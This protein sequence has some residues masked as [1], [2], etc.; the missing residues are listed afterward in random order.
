MPPRPPQV[1]VDVGRA[2]VAVDE[3]RAQ[4]EDE[5]VGEEEEEVRL[6]ETQIRCERRSR[7]LA[8]MRTLARVPI[9]QDFLVRRQAS[10]TKATGGVTA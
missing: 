7:R 6:Q 5:E 3:G 9:H 4:E 10:T 8:A 2:Q 1:V